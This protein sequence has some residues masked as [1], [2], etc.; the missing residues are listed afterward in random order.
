DTA[1]GEGPNYFDPQ[2]GILT[3]ISLDTTAQK[4][5]FTTDSTGQ[6]GAA[7]G[8]Y[9]LDLTGGN[10]GHVTTLWTQTTADTTSPGT[11]KPGSNLGYIVVD[12]T[13]G[14]Y[15]VEDGGTSSSSGVNDAAI[16]VGS[17]SGG[18]PTLFLSEPAAARLSVSGLGNGSKVVDANLKI[19]DTT[20]T[21][22]TS[23]FVTITAGLVGGDQLSV[24]GVTSGVVAGTSITANYN[25]ATGILALTGTDTLAHYKLAL[26]EVQ[27]HSTSGSPSGGR[28]ITFNLS[29]GVATDSALLNAPHGLALDLAPTLTGITGTA[30]EAVQGGS[31]VTLLIATPTIG[32]VD[33]TATAGATVQ[34]TN[35]QAGD[36]LFI[37]GVQSGT[38]DSGKVAVS[39]NSTTHTL[40]LTGVDSFAEYQTLLTQV[41]YQD[42]G[43]DTTTVGH[44]TRTI[45]WSVSDG[46]VSSTVTD[47]TLT[48]DRPPALTN[49]TLVVSTGLGGTTTSTA[50]QSVLASGQAVDRDGDTLTLTA[51]NGS[52]ANI[53]Q[54][55]NGSHGT[56]TL[57]SNGGFTYL[58]NDATGPTDSF[59]YT[60]SDGNGGVSIGTLTFD[61]PPEATSAAVTAIN[62]N[63]GTTT[64]DLTVGAT[65]T[66]TVTFNAVVDVTGT[67]LLALNDGA[68]ASY[69]SGSGTNALTFTYAVGASQNAATLASTGLS[70]GTID[71][72]AGAPAITTNAVATF[73]GVQI[74]TTP[75]TVSSIVLSSSQLNIANEASGVTA[76]VTFSEKVTGFD[77]KD[78]VL[79][80]G[81]HASTPTSSDGGLTW[82]TTLT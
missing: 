44:P 48:I 17:L 55:V 6:A 36:N 7:A 52:G 58:L 49:E 51:V 22:L 81:V 21:Q 4:L 60:I 23:A 31:A 32:D 63:T 74:D 72:A 78:L 14:V 9:E 35:A 66:I 33:N 46:L 5:Y 77:A 68:S 13:N 3:G 80:S 71:S 24:N 50:A 18:A 16:Y 73:T 57:S 82:T 62:G 25:S 42:G 30:T 61:L 40:S 10:A 11:G 37:S 41:T 8:I 29:N 65:V 75:P 15:Y 43:T 39:W 45:A 53:G 69:T 54:P 19:A 47:T 38:L 28:D 1:S 76:T 2:L 20:A 67:P 59:T 64:G 27:Y 12:H 56:L 79:P 70:G 34:V 26:D